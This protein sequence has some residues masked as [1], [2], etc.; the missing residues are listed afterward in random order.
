[1]SPMSPMSPK[2]DLGNESRRCCLDSG[3][4][5]FMFSDRERKMS[6]S[7]K[8]SGSI[9]SDTSLDSEDSY[10]SVIFVPHPEK[11]TYNNNNANSSFLQGGGKRTKDMMYNHRWA[12]MGL[13]G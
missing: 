11:E 3:G 7:S 8:D 6:D 5:D 1:M 4:G 13:E 2:M 12:R 10:V 9:Q